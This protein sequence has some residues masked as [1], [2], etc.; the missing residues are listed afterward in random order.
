LDGLA[1]LISAMSAMPDW[2]VVRKA[3]SNPR[4]ADGVGQFGKP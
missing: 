4:G 3:A 2:L 1:F